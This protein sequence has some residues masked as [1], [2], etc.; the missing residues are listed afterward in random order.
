MT[1]NKYTLSELDRMDVLPVDCNEVAEAY[2]REFHD[3]A[4]MAMMKMAREK[5]VTKGYGE[6]THLG[7]NGSPAVIFSFQNGICKHASPLHWFD[8]KNVFKGSVKFY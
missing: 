8:A 6:A 3:A 2:A 7:T 4:L 5:K 1:Q